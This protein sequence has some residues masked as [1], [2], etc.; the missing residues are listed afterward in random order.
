MRAYQA[1]SYNGRT[2]VQ[3]GRVFVGSAPVAQ[4]PRLVNANVTSLRAHADAVFRVEADAVAL[5][6]V[7]LT[8][9][10]QRAMRAQAREHG[11]ECF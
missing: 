7:R 4:G 10:A 8:A 5:Q 2:Y 11:W 3:F 9:T 6:E 1:T